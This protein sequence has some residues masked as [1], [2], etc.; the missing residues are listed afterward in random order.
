MGTFT[1]PARAAWLHP[2]QPWLWAGVLQPLTVA[3]I[4]FTEKLFKEN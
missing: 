1:T 2:A 3:E 4:R